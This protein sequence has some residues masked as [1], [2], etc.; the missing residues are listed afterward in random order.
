M[1]IRAVVLFVA[2]AVQSH[3]ALA[4]AACHESRTCMTT[5]HTGAFPSDRVTVTGML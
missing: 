5:T 3:D 2:L 1:C 4:D